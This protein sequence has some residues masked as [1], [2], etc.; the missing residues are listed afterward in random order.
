MFE[1]SKRG[2]KPSV[3]IDDKRNRNKITNFNI[4]MFYDFYDEK[5]FTILTFQ[6]HKLT[7]KSQKKRP[8]NTSTHFPPSIYTRSE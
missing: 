2:K 1:E 6:S 8:K 5:T 4:A 7:R 3:I